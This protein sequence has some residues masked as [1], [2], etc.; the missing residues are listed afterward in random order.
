MGWARD[1]NASPA[2]HA[3]AVPNVLNRD[4]APFPTPTNVLICRISAF[5]LVFEGKMLGMWRW[6]CWLTYTDACIDVHLVY[7]ISTRPYHLYQTS[8]KP[9]TNPA[10]IPDNPCTAAGTAMGRNGASSHPLLS[11]VL[12]SHNC[13]PALSIAALTRLCIT[14][15]TG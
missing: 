1:A 14:S 9:H 12:N 13:S 7:T 11:T 8:T 4:A 5:Q 2:K 10:S 15:S 3:V 6:D